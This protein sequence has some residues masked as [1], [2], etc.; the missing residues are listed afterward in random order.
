MTAA[1]LAFTTSRPDPALG[2]CAGRV[3][4]MAG[5]V[6]GAANLV[7]WGILGGAIDLHP[8]FLA[9]NWALA[10]SAFLVGS[11]RLRRIGG[12]VGCR[13]AGWSRAFI[14]S[15]VA[16]AL[17]LAATSY[18]AGDWSL[19]RWHA[20]GGLALYAAAWAIAALRTGTPNMGALFVIAL[21]GAGASATMLGT[22]D[23][24]L[25][26]TCTLLLAAF[27]P[28]LWLAFGRRL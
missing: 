10:V 27:L 28:G 18:L 8:A 22:P 16:L 2:V 4:L 3:L 6:F 26:Q 21:G 17:A 7:Q 13:V 1:A 15:H 19:M 24:Y 23:Q 11:L 5:L 20:V 9:L 14:L 12:P 25:I